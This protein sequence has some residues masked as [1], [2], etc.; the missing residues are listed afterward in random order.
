MKININL[1]R[2]NFWLKIFLL[3]SIIIFPTN[4]MAAVTVNGKVISNSEISLRAG[5]LRLERRGNSNNARLKMARDELIDEALKL[6][7]AERLNIKVSDKQVNDSYLNVARNLKLSVNNLNKVLRDNGVSAETL[8]NRLRAGIAW[9]G[10]T[11]VAIMPR[12]QI[13]DIELN[14]KAESQLEENMSYDF[15]LKEILFIIPK[16]SNISKSSRVAQANQYRKNFQGCDSAVELSLSYR[17]AAVLD[18]G[19]RH[20]TQLPKALANELSRLNVGGITKPRVVERGISMLAI[21]SKT[22]ARDL[23]FIKNN[24]RQEAGNEKLKSESDAYLKRLKERATI[25]YK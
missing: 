11:Q 18:I 14:Q 10:V 25:I 16:G 20:A 15:M 2:L 5:L 12:V 4:A 3:A 24:L 21:C 19:R 17:D 6:Q 13:S 8:K 23:T 9:Q 1:R 22:A 7:E